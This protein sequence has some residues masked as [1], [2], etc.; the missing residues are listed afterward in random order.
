VHSEHAAA[1]SAV[2]VSPTP[3]HGSATQ[4]TGNHDGYGRSEVGV[5]AVTAGSDATDG[6]RADGEQ[7]VFLAANNVN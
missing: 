7:T 1:A 3:S 5:G 6:S 4:N 2:A